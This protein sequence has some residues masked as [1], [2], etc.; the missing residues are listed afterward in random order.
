M[1]SWP[2]LDHATEVEKTEKAIAHYRRGL[3]S[4]TWGSLYRFADLSRAQ[5]HRY[6][7]RADDY[8]Q[9]QLRIMGINIFT[10]RLNTRQY[11]KYCWR[12][13][14]VYYRLAAARKLFSRLTQNKSQWRPDRRL[15]KAVHINSEAIQR[16][17]AS[18]FFDKLSILIKRRRRSNAKLISRLGVKLSAREVL[19]RLQNGVACEIQ[20]RA[21]IHQAALLYQQLLHRRLFRTFHLRPNYELVDRFH[22][23]WLRLRRVR[24]WKVFAERRR[25]HLSQMR[26]SGELATVNCLRRGVHCLL[27]KVAQRVYLQGRLRRIDTMYAKRAVVLH[28]IRWLR[29]V[30][31]RALQRATDLRARASLITIQ[32]YLRLRGAVR[33][34][35]RRAES[36]TAQHRRDQAVQCQLRQHYMKVAFHRIRYSVLYQQQLGWMSARAHHSWRSLSGALQQVRLRFRQRQKEI[37]D[38]LIALSFYK[39]Y[40]LA[41]GLIFFQRFAGR[42][43]A[44]RQLHCEALFAF[45]N[46]LRAEAC[47]AF[48]L[49]AVR[50]DSIDA[51][52]RRYLAR[53]YSRIWMERVTCRTG[54]ELGRGIREQFISSSGAPY[55]LQELPYGLANKLDIHLGHVFPSG[56]RLQPR[57]GHASLS[58]PSDSAE[59]SHSMNSCHLARA[60]PRVST[61]NDLL[62]SFNTAPRDSL[63]HR[64]PS[65]ELLPQP[66]VCEEQLLPPII[67]EILRRKASTPEEMAEQKR[68]FA[69]HLR[70]F[71]GYCQRLVHAGHL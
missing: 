38:C 46:T 35:H 43:R 3:I 13:S 23:R 25:L 21:R 33:L 28:L 67:P 2:D 8:R 9:Y 71:A 5:E 27:Q 44:L 62:L 58:S 65:S 14:L 70:E 31:E 4:R 64:E 41:R 30:K 56:V 49:E 22:V 66:S 59:R 63:S 53:K 36:S 42:K 68:L 57:D 40:R 19:Q 1:D 54:R 15:L 51:Y 39:T 26:A 11:L 55:E 69:R 17:R 12:L 48:I 61:F 20:R 24:Q 37:H 47:R 16:R 6:C 45:K 29:F 52:R 32:R 7:T 10:T 60:P 50:P 34:W 18:K